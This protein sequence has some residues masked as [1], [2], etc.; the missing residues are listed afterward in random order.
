MNIKSRNKSFLF[1]SLILLVLGFI[2]FK[3][4]KLPNKPTP[5][6]ENITALEFDELAKRSNVFILDVHIP[7]Q[8]HIGGTDAFIPFNEI[9]NNLDKLPEDKTA[10]ILV[11]CRSGNMSLSA[12]NTLVGLGYTSV[13]NLE[14]GTIAYNE[15]HTGIF[16]N[17][18]SRDLG[19]V[20]YGDV[21]T[22][23]FTLTNNTNDV[24]N[25]TKITSSCSCTSA[26]AQKTQLQ[27]NE[28]TILTVSFD[29][30]V[31]KDGTDLGDITRTIFVNTD[32]INFPQITAEITA[33]VIQ[34]GGE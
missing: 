10:P 17:P 1:I 8:A 3:S 7:E 24:V 5:Q 4:S 19:Q 29:P 27:P 25:I 30:A 9:S 31:H 18:E 21:A 11:Y 22:A 28:S 32:N 13:Y 16:I 12:S 26:K 33:K 23:D 20:I 6:Y 14:G 2:A 15:S 34:D